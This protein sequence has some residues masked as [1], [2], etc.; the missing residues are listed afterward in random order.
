MRSIERSL[1]SRLIVMRSLAAAQGAKAL[2]ASRRLTQK[3][4]SDSTTESILPDISSGEG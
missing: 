4:I 3:H 1:S 2:P